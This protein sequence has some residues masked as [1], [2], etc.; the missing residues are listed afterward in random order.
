MASY[1][2]CPVCGGTLKPGYHECP[3]CGFRLAGRT[4]SFKA[5]TNTGNFDS[6]GAEAE[7]EYSLYVAK[8][9][10][11]GEE[12]FLDSSPIVLGREPKCDVFLSDMTVSRNQSTI[13]LRGG[14][15]YIRDNGSLNG[16]W[17]EGKDIGGAE[18]EL[19]P[20]QKVQLGVF[21]LVLQSHV[22]V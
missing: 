10:Q 8:G 3:R 13:E 12:F 20:G 16:T 18:V 21:T 4:E 9:P 19:L 2:T 15:V 5:I 14:R 7:M 1:D 22:V 11:S 6:Q 17:V